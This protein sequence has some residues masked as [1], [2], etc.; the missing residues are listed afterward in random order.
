MS[1]QVLVA[2]AGPVGMTMAVALKRLGIDVRIVDKAAARTDKSKALVIWPRTLELLDIQGCL[3]A[4]L[5]AGMEGKG[6][7]I[8]ADGHELVHVSFGHGPQ[9]LPLR[10]ADPAKR[11]RA[12]AGGGAAAPGRDGGAAGRAAILRRRRRGVTAKLLHADGTVETAR[13]LSG[14]LRRRAQRRAPRPRHA[15][16]R[17]AT[18][19]PTGSWPTS[20]ID[21]ELAQDELTICWQPDGILAFFPIV[22]GRFRVI[23]DVGRRAPRSPRR[24]TLGGGAEAP[25]S[26][27]APPGP[28]GAT[29]PSGSAASASTSAR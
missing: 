26:T 14:R 25:R 2:G 19:P 15:R 20:V 18:V 5:D 28:A 4:F 6:A 27:A 1:E 3:Q 17:A 7:R 23:G 21:G 8:L 12:R 11:D 24:P 9:P 10:F 29:I 13:C 22:G 16:S